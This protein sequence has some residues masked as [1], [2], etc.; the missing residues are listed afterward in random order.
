MEDYSLIVDKKQRTGR[1]KLFTDPDTGEKVE[2]ITLTCRCK[3]ENFRNIKRRMKKIRIVVNADFKY[4]SKEE[5]LILSIEPSVFK[6]FLRQPSYGYE[7]DLTLKEIKQDVLLRKENG[8]D[9]IAIQKIIKDTLDGKGQTFAKRVVDTFGLQFFDLVYENMD[10]VEQGLYEEISELKDLFT[11]KEIEL[12]ATKGINSHDNLSMLGTELDAFGLSQA[13]RDEIYSSFMNNSR[14]VLK[15]DPFALVD[16]IHT[17]DFFKYVRK[18]ESRNDVIKS[19]MDRILMQNI[20]EGNTTVHNG[21]VYRLS[22]ELLGRFNISPNEKTFYD[23][24]Q[25]YSS[26]RD[27]ANGDRIMIQ[28]ARIARQEKNIANTLS[29]L[30]YKTNGIDNID[31]PEYFNKEQVQA[32]KD[33]VINNVSIIT[34]GAGVGKTTVLKEVIKTVLNVGDY[35]VVLVAPTGKAAQRMTEAINDSSFTGQT[36]HSFVAA[37]GSSVV[38]VTDT[39]VVGVGDVGHSESNKMSGVPVKDPREEYMT[40]EWGEIIEDENGEPIY[41]KKF[42]IMDE[43]AMA[44]TAVISSFLSHL[45]MEDKILFVGDV[46]QLDSIGC[47]AVFKDLINSGKFNVSYLKEKVRQGNEENALTK[48]IDD[49]EKKE[50]NLDSYNDDSVKFIDINKYDKSVISTSLYKHMGKASLDEMSSMQCLSPM[51]VGLFGNDEINDLI[52]NTEA[53]EYHKKAIYIKDM[54]FTTGCP[55]IVTKNKKEVDPTKSVLNG[56]I[57]NIMTINTVEIDYEKH[58]TYPKEIR[59]RGFYYVFDVLTNGTVIEFS[60]LKEWILK[61]AYSIS[62]HKSQGSEYETVYLLIPESALLMVNFNLI[63]TAI[64]RAKKNIVIIS[65]ERVIKRGLQMQ[66]QRQTGLSYYLSDYYNKIV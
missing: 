31:I 7:L 22:K 6:A 48:L 39:G 29:F 25:K 17:N 63:Y 35:K 45:R 12:L 46:Q 47:G 50:F 43:S 42:Y 66:E 44:S 58:M 18:I 38:D 64:T 1:G 56:Q 27:V 4:Y 23:V 2:R 24:L 65:T 21:E 61:P 13:Y 34:G 15:H 16:I 32:V 26:Y 11:A 5:E 54:A 28:N 52:V 10:L 8:I 49:V 57:G 9:E 51:N 53:A 62:I 60:E 41:V 3:G 40:D 19:S 30:N 20:K 14:H 36:V 37:A 33:S 55:V 59:E